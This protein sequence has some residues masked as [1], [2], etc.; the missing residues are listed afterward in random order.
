M[1]TL[2]IV[3]FKIRIV[4]YF[5]ILFFIYTINCLLSRYYYTPIYYNIRPWSPWTQAHNN[6][7]NMLRSFSAV[8]EK[9]ILL[10]PEKKFYIIIS[11]DHRRI[12]LHHFIG[13]GICIYT[14]GYSIIILYSYDHLY[15]DI[16][17]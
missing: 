10:S 4:R 17:I 5:D 11:L 14:G 16:I 13:I 8:V 2:Y 7:N 15:T 9:N 6:N 12:T 3:I 1:I